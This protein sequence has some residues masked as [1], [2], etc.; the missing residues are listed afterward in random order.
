MYPP[1]LLDESSTVGTTDCLTYVNASTVFSPT[2]S[3]KFSYSLKGSNFTLWLECRAPHTHPMPDYWLFLLANLKFSRAEGQLC[4]FNPPAEAVLFFS[5]KSVSV[6][7]KI[8]CRIYSFHFV[9]S[10][11]IYNNFQKEE[12]K[13]WE[14]LG[15]FGPLLNASMQFYVV[16]NTVWYNPQDFSQKVLI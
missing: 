8:L 9:W 14:V 2:I 1:R 7:S 3:E 10:R 4:V 16:T 13:T 6:L 5:D 11:T 12:S 15:T